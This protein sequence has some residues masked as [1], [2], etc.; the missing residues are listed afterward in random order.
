MAPA[1]PWSSPFTG[2]LA[3]AS[4]TGDPVLA[5]AS[6]LINLSLASFFFSSNGISKM[7]GRSLL[8]PFPKPMPLP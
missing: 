4:D 5:L 6:F 1:S 3:G 2:A 7:L 8:M